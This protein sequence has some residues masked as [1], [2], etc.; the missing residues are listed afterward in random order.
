MNKV[1]L[2]GRLVRDSELRTTTSGKNV[3]SFILAVSKDRPNKDGEYGTDFINCKAFEKKA[4]NIN[5]YFKKG[6]QIALTGSIN[7]FT[8]ETKDGVKKYST[9]VIVD[10][11]DFIGR[12]PGAKPDTDDQVEE[13]PTETEETDEK[14]PFQEFGEQIEI[15]TNDLPW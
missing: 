5:K 2:V 15:D 3:V 10:N 12:N 8:Y 1:E 13:T 9:E 4:V 11:F 14:D 6:S 7:T